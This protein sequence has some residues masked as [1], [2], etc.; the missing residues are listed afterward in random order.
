MTAEF[1]IGDPCYLYQWI[2]HLEEVMRS[3]GYGP[4]EDDDGNL[5][6]FRVQKREP[7][8]KDDEEFLE[9]VKDE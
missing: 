4:L 1:W 6:H 5:L 2:P 9:W 3:C 7:V 8:E